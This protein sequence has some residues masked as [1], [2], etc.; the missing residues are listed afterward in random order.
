M[1][2]TLV[3]SLFWSAEAG[4]SLFPNSWAPSLGCV[5]AIALHISKCECCGC[6]N[7]E[8]VLLFSQRSC[9]KNSSIQDH[10]AC[11]RTIRTPNTPVHQPCTHDSRAKIVDHYC[12]ISINKVLTRFELSFHIYIWLFQSLKFVM[13]C[14]FLKYTCRSDS[15]VISCA[16]WR[17]RF[18]TCVKFGFLI[19]SIGIA[20][21]SC[22]WSNN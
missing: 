17:L 6:G 7:C 15:C 13:T 8:S 2:S 20:F 3:C 21:Q 1:I 10:G 4:P 9:K 16:R 12:L 11:V 18:H 22:F 14:Y 19:W 5:C